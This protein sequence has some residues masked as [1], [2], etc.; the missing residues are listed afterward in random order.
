[1]EVRRVMNTSQLKEY[2]DNAFVS[3][4]YADYKGHQYTHPIR[5][6]QAIKSL[7][8]IDIHNPNEK[9]LSFLNSYTSK[10]NVLEKSSLQFKYGELEETITTHAFEKSLLLKNKN[11]AL[12]HLEQL[13]RVSDGRPILEILLEHSL[14][15]SG[16]SFPFLL[17]AFRANQFTENKNITA[18]LILSTKAILNDDYTANGQL[19]SQPIYLNLDLFASLIQAKEE[20]F[21]RSVFIDKLLPS[22]EAYKE[23]DLSL[24]QI[25]S[26]DLTTQGRKG[27]LKYISSL[28]FDAINKN[29][30]LKLDAIRSLMKN[31]KD[32]DVNFLESWYHQSIKE[33][34]EVI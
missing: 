5:V 27:I 1:M 15:Q 6:M 30:V 18:L 10:I 33:E 22:S 34:Y 11:N 16:V 23:L 12:Q 25:E 3:A 2:I 31:I 4:I 8:G 17:S 32:I 13:S 7:I 29:V 14:K 21:V 20:E 24:Q 26:L 9:L 19:I 28:E